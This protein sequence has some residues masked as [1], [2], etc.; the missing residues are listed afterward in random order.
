[1]TPAE[2]VLT[3]LT[4]RYAPITQREL[5]EL[6]GM[7]VRDVQSAIQSLVDEGISPIC[8]DSNGMR[9]ARS[10]AEIDT[11][12]R[13]LD[14]RISTQARR[15]RGLRMIRQRLSGQLCLEVAS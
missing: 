13:R 6:C 9:I 14:H 5:A 8:G 3:V 7:S 12:I 4:E 11:E 1:M 10:I 2:K 15:P